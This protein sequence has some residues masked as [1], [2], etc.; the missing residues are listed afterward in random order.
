MAITDINISEQLETGAPSIKYTG[1]EGPRPSMQSQQEMMIAQQIWEAMGDEERGQFSNFQEFFRSGIWKQI[2]QQAQQD[3]AQGIG[4]LGPRNMEQGPRLGAEYGGRIGYAGGSDDEAR[5]MEQAA[6]DLK[7]TMHSFTEKRG[8]LYID[9]NYDLDVPLTNFEKTLREMTKE[10]REEELKRLER[11]LQRRGNIGR[12]LGIPGGGKTGKERRMELLN[13]GT[14]RPSK[15]TGY[16][17]DYSMRH[18]AA[19]Y[20]DRPYADE[21]YETGEH[22]AQGGR[23]GARLGGD[24]EELSMRETINTPEGI[25]TLK[26]TDTMQMAGGGAR[27]W[28]AQM[29]AEQLADEQYGKDFYDL[30]QRTQMEIYQIA[31]DMIDSGGE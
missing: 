14:D 11:T 9:E 24:M 2:L 3:E 18:R 27:G 8:P 25:E 31:L 6:E 17:D 23:I 4:S 7:R 22:Y 29:L 21:H 13:W 16:F 20:L 12:D 10:E 1:K 15:D 26:E 28:K 30:P 19:E 5:A